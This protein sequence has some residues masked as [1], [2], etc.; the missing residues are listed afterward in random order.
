[1]TG[2]LNHMVRIIDITIATLAIILFLPLMV[3]ISILCFFDT[4][5]P[6]FT[7]Q[8]VG[9]MQK[10][11]TI[12][13]FRTMHVGT[14]SRATHLVSH[15]AVT[16]FGSFLRKTKLDELPQILNVIIGDM[17]I[18]GPRPCLLNQ[19]D[20]IKAR[21]S[22]GVFDARPGITGLAQ[23]RGIDMSNPQLLSEVDE[24]MVRNFNIYKYFYYI[25]MT[26]NLSSFGDRTS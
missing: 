23:I 6:F 12:F 10:P 7:Q 9:I 25:F 8:R 16:K 4:G 19:R 15:S 20:L 3:I 24:E 21:I 5:K 13:K 22:R 1:M 2:V 14:G 26:V 11:F 18:V 17:S